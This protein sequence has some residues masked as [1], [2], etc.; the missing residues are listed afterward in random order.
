MFVTF[1]VRHS[2]AEMYIGISH[3]SVCLSF[4]PLQ[5]SHTT[6]RTP[7]QLGGMVAG[8][9]LVVHYWADLQSAHGFCCCDNTHMSAYSLMHI[10]LNANCQRVLVLVPWLVLID[11]WVLLLC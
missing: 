3:L 6:A 11:E 1:N 7:L 4:W 5:H 9:P 2:Q 8:C 10:A